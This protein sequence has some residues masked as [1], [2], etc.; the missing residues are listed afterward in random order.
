MA[1]SI[2]WA[3][4]PVQDRER[5]PPVGIRVRVPALGELI[6]PEKRNPGS[7][8]IAGQGQPRRNAESVDHGVLSGVSGTIRPSPLRAA[9]GTFRAERLQNRCSPIA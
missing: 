4:G 6:L 8:I 9:Q 1:R 5:Y 3:T 7:S 2:R